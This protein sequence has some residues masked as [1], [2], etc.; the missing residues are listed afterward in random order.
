L[1]EKRKR[2]SKRERTERVAY[3]KSLKVF[4]Q[5]YRKKGHPERL[6]RV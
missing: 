5:K 2:T 4:S 1:R 3:I 6:K